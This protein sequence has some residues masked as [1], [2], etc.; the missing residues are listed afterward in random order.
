MNVP[1]LVD[2]VIKAQ[3][4]DTLKKE[5]DTPLHIYDIKKIFRSSSLFK[6]PLPI[7]F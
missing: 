4:I 2:P 7:T 5:L 6:I 3:E 1:S